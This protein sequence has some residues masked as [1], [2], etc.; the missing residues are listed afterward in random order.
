M[1]SSSRPGGLVAALA[2]LLLI[3][4]GALCAQSRFET[5]TA[6]TG[7]TVVPEPG[8]KIE[9]ECWV[10]QGGVRETAPL[11]LKIR[12]LVNERLPVQDDQPLANELMRSSKRFCQA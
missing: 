12:H 8:R 9:G 6:I 2:A 10:P 1:P 3:G 5:P 11:V 7:L 4:S